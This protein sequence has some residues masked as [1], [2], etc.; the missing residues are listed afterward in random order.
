[1]KG[2]SA[3][4]APPGKKTKGSPTALKTG[5]QKSRLLAIV[6]EAATGKRRKL[7]NS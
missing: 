4:A 7:W 2:K 6:V 3:K 5:T 1:M